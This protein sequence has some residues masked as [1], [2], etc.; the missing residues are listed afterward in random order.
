MKLRS[1]ILF[2]ILA[3][4]RCASVAEEEAS[5]S[6]AVIGGESTDESFAAV[7]ALVDA[8]GEPFCS[9]TLIRKDMVLT[10]AHCLTL[11]GDDRPL[12]PAN[13]RFVLG[14]LARHPK[15]R[16][17]V[18][19]FHPVPAFETGDPNIFWPSDVMLVAIDRVE[20]VDPIP[21]GSSPSDLDPSLG[22][23]SVGFG[24]RGLEAKVKNGIRERLTMHL[25]AKRGNVLENEFGSREAFYR[26]ASQKLPQLDAAVAFSQGEL[27][28][29]Y[30]L[31]GRSSHGNNCSGDSGGPLLQRRG[32]R[33]EVVAVVSRGFKQ[34]DGV[35]AP[36]GMIFASFGPNT[37]A[38]IDRQLGVPR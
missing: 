22:F 36:L 27:H 12:E 7:G 33:F 16:V 37:R 31:F 2:T 19:A 4:L 17:A 24:F 13:V 32:D 30:E 14:A 6:G 15:R 21:I 9:G 1:T 8:K 18:R 29:G 5:Q 26:Y 20:D 3:T 25:F 23:D 10:A 11:D 28:E 35:C 34:V 38:H